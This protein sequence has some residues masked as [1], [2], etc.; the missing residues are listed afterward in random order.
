MTETD[1]EF[2]IQAGNFV[3]SEVPCESAICRRLR[4]YLALTLQ[5]VMNE[6]EPVDYSE[7]EDL[8]ESEDWVLANT[9]GRRLHI[10]SPAYGLD[11]ELLWR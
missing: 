2:P 6:D 7:F 8:I 3:R 4:A 5:E 11:G 1:S 10:T 9:E